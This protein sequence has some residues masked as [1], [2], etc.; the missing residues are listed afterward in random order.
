MIRVFSHQLP[1]VIWALLLSFGLKS[2]AVSTNEVEGV[3]N[4]Q[5][6]CEDR[7]NP[8]CSELNRQARLSVIRTQDSLGVAVGY[9]EQSLSRYVFVSHEL[10]L[11]NDT[12][13][14]TPSLKNSSSSAHFSEVWINFFYEDN[15]LVAKGI[16][17]DARFLKDIHFTGDQLLSTKSLAPTEILIDGFNSPENSEGRF[18]AKGTNRQW[19]VTVRQA[20]GS[21]L[22]TDYIVEIT[23]QGNP[24]GPELASGDRIYL[25]SI[26]SS[27]PGT[28]E[29]IAPLSQ[30]GG[31]LKWVLWV[32]P[33]NLLRS[34][35]LQG[36]FYSSNGVFSRLYFER[37]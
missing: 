2:Q 1:L 16:I 23:D 26:P 6:V 29:L 22:G 14:G 30:P 25:R 18:L 27:R 31:F 32:S 11:K 17:R 9:P 15:K 19:L 37:L 13:L 8:N 12:Y 4:I 3:F 21:E 33:E 10:E 7:T 35:K 34:T 20:L 5:M 28:M 24:N 36:F